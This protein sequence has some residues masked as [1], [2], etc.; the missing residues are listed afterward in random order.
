MP[1]KPSIDKPI[2]KTIFLPTSLIARVDL[3]LYSELE[4]RVPYNAWGRYV[5]QLIKDDLTKKGLQL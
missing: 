1:R 5:S 2:A 4:G 3:T